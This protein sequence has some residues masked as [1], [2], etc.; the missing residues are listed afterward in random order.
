MIG[1][2]DLEQYFQIWIILLLDPEEYNQILFPS[3]WEMQSRTLSFTKDASWHAP[4][5][6][7][8]KTSHV[9]TVYIQYME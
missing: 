5:H 8:Y 1:L 3:W 6:G 4:D 7:T 9:G 2:Q